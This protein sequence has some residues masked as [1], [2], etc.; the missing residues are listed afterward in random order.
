MLR[1]IDVER[2]LAQRGYAAGVRAE[3]HLEVR[4]DRLP[5]NHGRFVL[6]GADGKATVRKGGSG[7]I[8][9]DVRGLASTYT[10]FLSP[11]DLRATG[12]VEAPTEALDRLASIFAGPPPW[13]PDGF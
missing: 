5:W 12:Y 4:D 9:I 6:E 1:L 8:A 13:M 3:L 11:Y 10:G 2:A 7:E